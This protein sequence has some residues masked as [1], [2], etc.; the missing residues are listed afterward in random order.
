MDKVYSL[1]TVVPNTQTWLCS[2]SI[3]KKVSPEGKITMDYCNTTN[4]T[5]KNRTWKVCLRDQAKKRQFYKDL[6]RIGAGM[7]VRRAELVEQVTRADRDQTR[8]EKDMELA[9]FKLAS[10]ARRR[11]ELQKEFDM[12]MEPKDGEI[13]KSQLRAILDDFHNNIVFSLV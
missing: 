3:G 4:E 6:G 8:Y 11:A 12:F 7:K 10:K 9:H 1:I 13:R 2:L 5:Y